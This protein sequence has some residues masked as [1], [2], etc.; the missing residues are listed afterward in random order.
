MFSK[1]IRF[2]LKIGES[3]LLKR[4]FAGQ[5]QLQM[6]NCMSRI[7]LYIFY[8][9]KKIL[10]LRNKKV[11]LSF[12]LLFIQISSVSSNCFWYLPFFPIVLAL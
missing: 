6:K 2:T 1:T 8:L 10:S 5:L 9:V 12:T 3:G 11:R 4:K 7:L